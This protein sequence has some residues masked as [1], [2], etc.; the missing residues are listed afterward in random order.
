MND[1]ILQVVARLVAPFIQLYGIYII[2]HG[3]LSPGGGF[4]GGTILGTSLILI[5]LSYSPQ[6]GY[7]IMSRNTTKILESSGGLWFIS[8]GFISMLLG[9]PYLTNRG[10]FPI[11]VAGNLFSSGMVILLTLGIGIKVASTIITL[12]YH[13]LEEGEK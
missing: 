5:A 13:L 10:V 11:G 4:A 12:F 3:H 6:K 7:E 8:V 1:V 9:K 2:V